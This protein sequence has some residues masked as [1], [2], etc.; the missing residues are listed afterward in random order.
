[1]QLQ[2]LH[3][4]VAIQATLVAPTRAAAV[5]AVLVD[6]HILV[7]LQHQQEQHFQLP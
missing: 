6:E 2:S 4:V 3:S 1:M 7:G 5:Q